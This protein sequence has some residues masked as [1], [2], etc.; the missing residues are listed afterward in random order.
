MNWWF[1]TETWDLTGGKNKFLKLLHILDTGTDRII[2][3]QLFIGQTA[4]TKWNSI[5]KKSIY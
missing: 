3:V 4:L 1:T 5:A 2:A